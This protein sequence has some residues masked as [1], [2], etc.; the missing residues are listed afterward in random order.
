MMRLQ[1]Q[2][3]TGPGAGTCPATF[4]NPQL[5]LR[6]TK[7][8]GTVEECA[9]LGIRDGTWTKVHCFRRGPGLDCGP[10]LRVGSSVTGPRAMFQEL[11]RLG[12]AAPESM[13]GIHLQTALLNPQE[14]PVLI[15][16]PSGTR[17]QPSIRVSCSGWTR[18]AKQRPPRG[19]P[20]A[21]SHSF[22]VCR[23]GAHRATQLQWRPGAMMFCHL[24]Q[25]QSVVAWTVQ[26]LNSMSPN[27]SLHMCTCF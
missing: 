21:S 23:W 9:D 26:S 6:R 14:T 10:D 27:R 13:T 16:F 3:E 20:L 15:H 8:H 19:H 17:E 7:P 2:S 1:T 25:G 18:T 11:D 5:H 22:S 24:L 12:F 4:V